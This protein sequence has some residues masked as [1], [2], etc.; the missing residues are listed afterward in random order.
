ME[1][2]LGKVMVQPIESAARHQRP[3]RARGEDIVNR[4]A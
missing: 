1:E 3:G 4:L 2:S